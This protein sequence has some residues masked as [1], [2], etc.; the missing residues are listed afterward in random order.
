MRFSDIMFE[1]QEAQRHFKREDFERAN[2][3]YETVTYYFGFDVSKY[4]IPVCC[5]C[6]KIKLNINII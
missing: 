3:I 1:W 4:N 5:Q 2:S 6:I